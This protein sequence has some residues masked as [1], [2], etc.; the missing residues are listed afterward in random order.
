MRKKILSEIAIYYGDV[1][2]PKGF[3][4]D[5]LNI[6]KSIMESLYNKQDYT[7]TKEFDKLNSYVIEYMRLKHNLIL[8]NRKMYG[9]I[10]IPNENDSPPTSVNPMDLTNSP[11]FTLLY[12][13]NTVDCL[14]KIYYDNNR[15]K[16]LCEE[17]DLKQNLFV[18]FPSTC[19]Y[20]I[21][22]NQKNNLNFIQTITY[23][24]K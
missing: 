14:V 4:I 8:I 12:G 16:N 9:S 22:N 17:V 10:Y 18:M 15:I 5:S 13:V 19:S 3:N 23:E 24:I 7:F 20:H 1:S 6:S 21:I 2:M 11:D